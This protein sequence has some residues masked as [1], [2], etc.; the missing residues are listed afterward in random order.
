[1]KTWA[2]GFQEYLET[3]YEVRLHKR[4]NTFGAVLWPENPQER[5]LEIALAALDR[6]SANAQ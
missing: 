2:D 1:M 5:F 4:R 3:A 6:S